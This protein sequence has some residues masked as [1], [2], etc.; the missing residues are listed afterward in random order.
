MEGTKELTA[1]I[2][3]L[4]IAICI[5]FYFVFQA[6]PFTPHE[7]YSFPR[8]PVLE[9]IY[10][11]EHHQGRNATLSFVGDTRVSCRI[12]SYFMATFMAGSSSYDCGLEWELNGKYVY[13]ERVRV[14]TKNSDVLPFVVRITHDGRDYRNLS[15]DRVRALW[16]YGTQSDASSAAG[17]IWIV[18]IFLQLCFMGR[19]QLLGEFMRSR[20]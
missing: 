9:G 14:P 3:G 19:K 15:D 7:S 16:I 11:I 13:V 12:A 1:F 5:Y 20:K 6:E 2:P 4:L 10:R 18:L 8:E 17:F